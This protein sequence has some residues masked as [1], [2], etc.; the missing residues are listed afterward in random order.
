MLRGCGVEPGDRVAVLMLN[1]PKY[2]ELYYACALIDVVI[3]PVNIRLGLE[4]IAFWLNDSESKALV[5]DN[6]F[7]AVPFDLGDKL[8]TVRTVLN[9]ETEHY[10]QYVAA[11]SN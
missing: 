2:L 9:A 6:R 1:S 8:T 4:E 3:V 5:V 11:A 7:A 10:E